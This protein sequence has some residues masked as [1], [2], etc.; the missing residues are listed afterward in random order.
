MPHPRGI[1]QTASSTGGLY[2]PLLEQKGYV[3]RLDSGDRNDWKLKKGE[4]GAGAE[5]PT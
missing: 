5:A 4:N 1:I 3:P 2:G